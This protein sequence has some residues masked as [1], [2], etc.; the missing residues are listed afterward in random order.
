M[1][2]EN[3]MYK[4]TFIIKEFNSD[5]YIEQFNTDRSVEWTIKQYSRNRNIEY[6]NLIRNEK[7]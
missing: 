3:K 5:E 2:T 4:Y 1:S 6:M 7:Q